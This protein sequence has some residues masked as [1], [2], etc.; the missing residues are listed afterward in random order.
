MSAVFII[1]YIAIPADKTPQKTPGVKI[2]SLPETGVGDSRSWNVTAKLVC[3]DGNVLSDKKVRL[4]YVAWP[5]EPTLWQYSPQIQQGGVNGEVTHTVTIDE[6][7]IGSGVYVFLVDADLGT[8]WG[9]LTYE[10]K[11]Y[12]VGAIKD[13]FFGEDSWMVRWD[14]DLF[15]EG[16]VTLEYK[17]PEEFCDTPTSIQI[18][19]KVYCEDDGRSLNGAT[20]ELRDTNSKITEVIANPNYYFNW[21]PE[22]GVEHSIR[23]TDQGN[24]P[25][26]Y[27]GPYALAYSLTEV[28]YTEGEGYEFCDFNVGSA[29]TNYDF[30]FRDCE[31]V[32]QTPTPTVTPT[33]TLTPTPTVTV[34]VTTTV[35][36]TPSGELN[37]KIFST[38]ETYAGDFGGISGADTIC[39]N[40]ASDAGLDGVWMSYLSTSEVD[41]I[42]R[43]TDDGKFVNIDGSTIADSIDDLFSCDTNGS[44][45]LQNG[46]NQTEF[47]DTVSFKIAWT[48]TD[49]NGIAKGGNDSNCN[50]WT[51]Q[52]AGTDIHG[53]AGLMEKTNGD[54]TDFTLASCNQSERIYCIEQPS[55][56]DTECNQ[57]I[58]DYPDDSIILHIEDEKVYLYETFINPDQE[59]IP[60]GITFCSD[61]IDTCIDVDGIMWSPRTCGY[62]RSEIA[63]LSFPESKAMWDKYTNIEV[64]RPAADY[65]SGRG[66][67][68]W[69]PYSLG[70]TRDLETTPTVTPIPPG[71][72][73]CGPIDEF[74]TQG[75][76]LPDLQVTIDDF[77]AFASVYRATCNDNDAVDNGDYDP[78]GGRNRR[79]TS[80]DD[81]VDI[82]DFIYFSTVYRQA[83]CAPEITELAETGSI[84]EE[85]TF[86][87][88]LILFNLTIGSTALVIGSKYKMKKDKK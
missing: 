5:P 38:S 2:E 87:V 45:C 41:A 8:N 43:F 77:I 29:Y 28:P 59:V 64:F 26:S 34:T 48:G 69:E 27:D 39:E 63:N 37:L 50:N 12:P 1:T 58:L 25:S 35:T 66:A 60:D 76:L 53:Y 33:S 49:I 54:W 61:D 32:E 20:T 23:M 3:S 84:D 70:F 73:V 11:T 47:G 9:D 19:G 21:V 62:S 7:L 22:N 82:D 85:T 6:P 13:K 86:R 17:A 10:P 42:D 81:T 80:S 46:I 44:N 36:P 56:G 67:S 40:H 75:N 30:V 14:Q 31:E 68:D 57:E 16:P 52:G 65:V 24:I 83:T 78:C 79:F 18:G 88:I 51:E 74:D 55:Y 72:E 4:G 15:P 71:T